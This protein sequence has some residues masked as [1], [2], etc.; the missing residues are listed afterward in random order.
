MV[1]EV[2]EIERYDYIIDNFREIV[3]YNFEVLRGRV[4]KVRV[5]F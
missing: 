5:K 1:V 4:L 3:M 2:E